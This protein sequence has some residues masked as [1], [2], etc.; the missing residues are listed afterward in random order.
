VAAYAREIHAVSALLPRAKIV[1]IG[2]SPILP[3]YA[4]DC[5][6]EHE[7]NLQACTFDESSIIQASET[8]DGLN[9]ETYAHILARDSEVAAASG[10]ELIPS[11]PWLC[12]N[13]E[14]PVTIGD[15]LVYRDDRHFFFPF[16]DAL[17]PVIDHAL[18]KAHIY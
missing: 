16:L 13:E 15:Y 11:E 10:A 2:S 7:E 18:H 1:L 9:G 4:P 5:V 12:Y 17:G 6:M 14:C 8:S 3:T